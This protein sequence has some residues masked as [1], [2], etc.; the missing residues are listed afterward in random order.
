M[1]TYMEQSKNMFQQMQEQLQSQTRTMFSGF[2]FPGAA[3]GGDD[4]PKSGEGKP[5]KS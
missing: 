3:A 2:P 5:E 1:S 4:G